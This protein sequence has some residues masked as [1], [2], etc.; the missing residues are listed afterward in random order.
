MVYI[1]GDIHGDMSRFS[2]PDMR[3]VKKG[4]TL[5]VCGD[6]G[7]VWTGSKKEK[8]L[9]KKLGKLPYTVAFLDGVHEN[10]DLLAAY[11]VE[12]WNG[13][14]AQILD[15]RLVHLLRGEIYDIEGSRFFAFGGGQSPERD[16]REE[17]ETWW[18]A[19]MPSEAE[20]TGGLA[21]LAENGNRI[22]YIL[23]HEPSGKANGYLSA[24]R[25]LDGLNV[26]LNQLE[27]QVNYRHWYFGSLHRDRQLSKQHTAVF[28]RVLPVDQ[29]SRT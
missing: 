27:E 17:H 22:D 11:P 18:E 9:L 24:K 12:E 26:Y 8:K 21:R 7:F 2:S 16:I 20:M 15:G 6:F 10:Y 4:D 13:G 25:A 23:T 28:R 19:E 3:R 5:L 1:T 29:T 14:R